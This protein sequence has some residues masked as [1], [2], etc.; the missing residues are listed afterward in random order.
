MNLDLIRNFQNYLLSI[1]DSSEKY[2]KLDISTD[3]NSIFFDF[4][5]E[6]REYIKQN[7]SG[8]VYNSIFADGFDASDILK[9]SISSDGEIV[10]NNYSQDIE[11]MNNIFETLSAEEKRKFD[12]DYDENISESEIL[13]FLA[14]S[15]ISLE[16]DISLEELQEKV[17]ELLSGEIQEID[18]VDAFKD[19]DNFFEIKKTEGAQN[20]LNEAYENELIINA[21]D[22]NGD[23][24]LSD[25]EKAKFEQ[26]SLSEFEA[27]E[28]DESIVQDMTQAI[29]DGRFSYDGIKE[30]V[31]ENNNAEEVSEKIKTQTPQQT[32]IQTSSGG[33][34]SVANTG[35]GGGISSDSGTSS[36]NS[37][38]NTEKTDAL[39]DLKTKQTEQQ[40]VVSAAQTAVSEV[41][42]KGQENINGAQAEFNSAKEDF[43]SAQKEYEEA[44]NAEKYL[45]KNPKKGN[46]EKYGAQIEENL[47]NIATAQVE[48]NEAQQNLSKSEQNV[49]INSTNVTNAKISLNAVQAQVLALEAAVS[50]FNGEE[51][52]QGFAEAKAALDAAKAEQSRVQA[53]LDE[54]E[55]NL[56]AAE[57]ELEDNKTAYETA[58]TNLQTYEEAKAELDKV[59]EDN[60]SDSLKSA[61]EAYD[62][63]KSVLDEK[64]RMLE[65]ATKEQS[66]LAR[67]AEKTLAS[68]QTKLDDIDK[69]INEKEALES[70][71]QYFNNKDGNAL[72][73]FAEKFVGNSENQMEKICGYDLP[74]GLWCAA[75]V[76]YVATEVLGNEKLPDWY[77][78]CNYNSCSEILYAAERNGSASKDIA[79]AKA[80]DAIIFNTSRGIARHIGYVIKVEDGKVY[81]VEGNSSGGEVS[82]KEYDLN[83]TSKLN[84]IVHLT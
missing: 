51:D 48:K 36:N 49:F 26:F 14:S 81:T 69:L 8:E 72:V 2:A 15:D 79:S 43:D 13:E 61:K 83:D 22:E 70:S 53:L 46:A 33:S 16:D 62:R 76:K 67:E 29:F 12:I 45:M 3:S 35:G 21:I 7:C 55:E 57:Q 20:L 1:D 18:D 60:C 74:D 68:E 44:V 75:F 71:A 65:D 73:E 9:L 52:V 28:L 77:K 84:S 63:A 54:A 6:F 4:Q 24:I 27:D 50:S 30:K 64:E 32:A 80:G 38:T 59:I 17:N 19:T 34:S 23:F 56:A 40:Q 39:K 66:E 25:E 31:A 5:D 82:Y 10:E 78:N 11:M 37:S 58:C 42:T 47:K 41:F